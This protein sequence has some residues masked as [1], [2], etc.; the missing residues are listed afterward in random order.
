MAECKDTA[1]IDPAWIANLRILLL[2]HTL[3]PGVFRNRCVIDQSIARNFDVGLRIIGLSRA[4]GSVA[5]GAPELKAA[6]PPPHHNTVGGWIAVGWAEIQAE[7][8]FGRTLLS[9]AAVAS[10]RASTDGP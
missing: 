6:S 5:V 2:N 9:E 7:R 8:A 1:W 4:T 3:L 10:D